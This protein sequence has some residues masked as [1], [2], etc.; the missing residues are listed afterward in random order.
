[1]RAKTPNIKHKVLMKRVSSKWRV[2]RLVPARLRRL[3]LVLDES[4]LTLACGLSR[5]QKQKAEV[6]K[7]EQEE[8]E[9][10]E[11]EAEA[12]KKGKDE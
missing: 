6:L 4:A 7:E 2:R 3:V 11:E 9:G 8:A 1:M 12:Q 10:D 5:S